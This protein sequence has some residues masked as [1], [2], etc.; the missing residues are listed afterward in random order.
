MLLREEN[1]EMKPE[2]DFGPLREN[3][4]GRLLAR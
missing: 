4:G 1:V 3:G 2:I